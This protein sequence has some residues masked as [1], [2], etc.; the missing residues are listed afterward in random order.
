M[1]GRVF[2]SNVKQVC[3]EG[4][5]SEGRSVREGDCKAGVLER[6]AAKEEGKEGRC[7]REG[8]F[9]GGVEENYA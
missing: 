5:V 6:G 7:V 2:V 1:K 8:N 4:K 3:V 9:K